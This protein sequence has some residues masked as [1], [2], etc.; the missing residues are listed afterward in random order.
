MNGLF[1]CRGLIRATIHMV[2][3]EFGSLADDF[4]ALGL[5][6][7]DADL[8]EIVPALTDVFSEALRGGVSNV[9]FGELSN[10]LGQTMYKYNFRIPA[11][12]T[13]LVRSLSVLEVLFPHSIPLQN[14]CSMPD[15]QGLGSAACCC[16][17]SNAHWICA[18]LF[19]KGADIL[20]GGKHVVRKG[21]W[22]SVAYRGSIG[23]TAALW[24]AQSCSLG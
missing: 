20:V 15:M 22:L 1:A 8:D 6:P 7:P 4:V 9:S 16:S 19:V 23:P 12:Y 5:L 3:R 24:E 14:S 21:K 13:L 2:N 11:Y 18:P 10:N 17:A